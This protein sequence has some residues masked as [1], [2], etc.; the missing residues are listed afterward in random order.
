MFL[1]ATRCPGTRPRAAGRRR[2]A[3]ESRATASLMTPCGPEKRGRREGGEGGGRDD[4]RATEK[5]YEGQALRGTHPRES[6]PLPSGFAGGRQNSAPASPP[7]PHREFCPSTFS[8]RR[9]PM[10]PH[11]QSHQTMQFPAG[12]PPTLRPPPNNTPKMPRL[13]KRL[14]SIPFDLI[15]IVQ[16]VAVGLRGLREQRSCRLETVL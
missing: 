11:H 6:R 1:I 9:L 16:D 4:R 13:G 5:K 7:P 15:K 12:P 8:A 14:Q 2:V 10:H 3:T